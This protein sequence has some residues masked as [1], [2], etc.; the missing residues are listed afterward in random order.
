MR[1]R[2]FTEGG[3]V[4]A[5][6]PLYQIDARLY[7]AAVNEAD[8]NLASARA[9]AQAARARAERFR[10]LAEMEAISQQDFTDAEAAARAANAAVAQSNAQL[11]TARI[12]LGF[13]TITAPINGQIGRSLVTEGAL[14]TT[15]QSDPLAI[16]QRIDTVFVDMQQS[17]SELVALRRNIASGGAGPASS[18]VRLRLE[19]GRDYGPS[20]QLEFTEVISN[21]ATGTVTLRARFPNP[22]GML[23]PGMFVRARFSPATDRQA[24]LVPQVAVSRDERGMALVWIV[25]KDGKVARRV[26]TAT[27]TQGPNWVVTAGLKPGEHVV[28][29][30]VANLRPGQSVRAVPANTPQRI[31]PPSADTPAG[32][33][34]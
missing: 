21:A 14:V 6:Q 19:D 25:G 8:A 34:P 30:G 2:L 32:P 4:R 18:E 26:I 27:R 31:A 13:T 16:I 29:Q 12:S 17:G 5:G 10:P 22:Q 1:R 28:T 33:R 20:G 11:D 7:R 15:S 9:N 3:F 24:I 23:L